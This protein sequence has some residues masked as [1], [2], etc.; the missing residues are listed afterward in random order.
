MT[1]TQEERLAI[2]VLIMHA[3]QVWPHDNEQAVE[4]ASEIAQRV[5]E[6]AKQEESDLRGGPDGVPDT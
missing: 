2:A 1:L 5:L 3:Q 6:R 4:R